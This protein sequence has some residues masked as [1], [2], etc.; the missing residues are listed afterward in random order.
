VFLVKPMRPMRL[1]LPHACTREA[2]IQ[3][4]RDA[5]LADARSLALSVKTVASKE[6]LPPSDDR[7][8]DVEKL[9]R[10]NMHPVHPFELEVLKVEAIKAPKLA[11]KQAEARARMVD[12]T[13]APSRK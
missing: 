11:F 6:P 2:D 4:A 8:I 12:P 9:V 3:A 13:C 1:C 10:D 5:A 7:Y